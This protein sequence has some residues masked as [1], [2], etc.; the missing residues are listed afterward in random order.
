MNRCSMLLLWV[1]FLR[2]SEENFAKKIPQPFWL[3]EILDSVIL[4]RALFRL[5][6]VE[7]EYT[8]TNEN[9]R[10]DKID[11]GNVVALGDHYLGEDN[12]EYGG[13]KAEDGYAGNGVIL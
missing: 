3:G 4:F 8:G 5:L 6:V 12:A 7:D 1:F 13:H 10:C 2:K 11:N 9:K